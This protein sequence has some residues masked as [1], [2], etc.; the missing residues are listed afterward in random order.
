MTTPST[1][2]T[3]TLPLG[4]QQHLHKLWYY[5]CVALRQV[6][7]IHY[8]VVDVQTLRDER[9][10][11]FALNISMASNMC[12]PRPPLGLLGI[13]DG[14]RLPESLCVLTDRMASCP[15]CSYGLCCPSVDSDD[16]ILV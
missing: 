9:A 16:I 5:R 13:T 11:N 12:V 2:T 10:V 8:N 1:S 15:S 14:S 7:E 6:D 4:M 3:C